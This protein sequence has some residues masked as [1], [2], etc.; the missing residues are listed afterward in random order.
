MAVDN[1]GR[2][3]PTGI[4]QRGKGFEGRFMYKGV[5]HSVQGATVTETQKAMTDLKYELEHGI[6]VKRQN[7]LLT[8]WMEEWLEGYLK[9]HKKLGTYQTYRSLYDSAI[10]PEI[11]LLKIQDVT[12][13]T[14]EQIY[15][16]IKKKRKYSASSMELIAVIMKGSFKRAKKVQLIAN[17]PAELAELPRVPKSEAEESKTIAMTKAQQDLFMECAKDSYLYNLFYVLLR[18]GLRIGEA[19]ALKYT[20]I[21]RKNKKLYVRRT[22]KRIKGEFVE[23]TPKSKTSIREIPLTDSVIKILDAQRRFW[24]FKVE[25]IDRYLFCDM[26]GKPL[27]KGTI[28]AEIKR[29][30]EQARKKDKEFPEITPHSFRHT[31]ATRAIEAG[32]PPQVLKTILGHSSYAMTMDLYAHVL[33][34]VKKDEMEK[35]EQ[36]F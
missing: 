9:D 28:S 27:W 11:A 5:A 16:R 10:K 2:K 29:I 32:M 25:R 18:T 31:F 17:N 8:E 3:L 4:R 15:K 36:A 21:D 6:Y 23:D 33:P 12:V 7:M 20:D 13:D 19:Q 14:V 30:A 1:R 35:I 26:D 22:L 24:G 34:D